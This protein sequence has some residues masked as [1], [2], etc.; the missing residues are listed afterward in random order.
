M[1][2]T[3][4][5]CTGDVYRRDTVDR[6]HYPVFHQTEGVKVFDCWGNGALLR[7]RRSCKL[8]CAGG[9]S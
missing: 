7:E 3:A 2:Q 6:S 4:F 8:G 9:C 1:S 5:L